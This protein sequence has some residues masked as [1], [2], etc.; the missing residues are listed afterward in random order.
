VVV[1]IVDVLA[2]IIGVVLE[3][4]L[5]VADTEDVVE[6][7]KNMRNTSDQILA[8]SYKGDKCVCHKEIRYAERE[9]HMLL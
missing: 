5:R 1:A 4:E 7:K 2:V 9:K 8:N 6:T 3:V